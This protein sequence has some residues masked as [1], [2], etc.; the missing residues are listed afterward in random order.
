MPVAS[1]TIT[2]GRPSANRAYQ[3][4]TSLV[5]KPS[6][7]ARH[8]TI[9]G[10]H[11]RVRA[12]RGPT[13]SGWNN[14]ASAAASAVGQLAG[15]SSNLIRSV[16]CHI[17]PNSYHNRGVYKTVTVELTL[18]C[19]N[20]AGQVA[21]GTL[22][23]EILCTQCATANAFPWRGMFEIEVSG[24][25]VSLS[26]ALPGLGEGATFQGSSRATRLALTIEPLRCACGTAFTEAQLQSIGRLHATIACGCGVATPARKPPEALVKAYP[27]VTLVVG[28]TAAAV[29]SRNTGAMSRAPKLGLVFRT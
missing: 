10:T 19:V 13:P 5:T 23:D 14:R 21:V 18:N 11:V 16:G 17:A 26:D 3:S 22:A 1:T 24:M 7:V 29:G 2:P 8:G 28:E 12:S 4:I 6:S 27:N 9:A 15:G 20:C 25:T